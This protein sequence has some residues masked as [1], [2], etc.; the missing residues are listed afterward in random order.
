MR[1]LEPML[2]ERLAASWALELVRA[3]VLSPGLALAQTL[4]ASWAP[5]LAPLQVGALVASSLALGRAPLQALK[6]ALAQALILGPVLAQKLA[7]AWALGL[8]PVQVPVQVLR[9]EQGP[10]LKMGSQLAAR[11]SWEAS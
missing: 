2:A 6:E 11:P 10:E 9:L 3:W 7:A 1:V 4:A 5:E 8:G